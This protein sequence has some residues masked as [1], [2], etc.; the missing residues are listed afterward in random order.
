MQCQETLAER[1]LEMYSKRE[2]D[3]LFTLKDERFLLH[4]ALTQ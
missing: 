2:I 1:G 3:I 4:C